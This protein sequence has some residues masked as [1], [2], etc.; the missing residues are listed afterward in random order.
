MS[1]VRMR[2]LLPVWWAFFWRYFLFSS[3]GA[4]IAVAAVSFG[5]GVI[6]IRTGPWGFLPGQIIGLAVS[7]PISMW[8]LRTALTRH[9][10]ALELKIKKL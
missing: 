6:G 2:D 9:Y 10:Y 5:L 8:T 3:V 1:D 7:V 4:A